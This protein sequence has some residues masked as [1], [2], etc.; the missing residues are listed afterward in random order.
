MKK[1]EIP[2]ETK[3][4]KELKYAQIDIV[5]FVEKYNLPVWFVVVMVSLVAL[6]QLGL[7]YFIKDVWSGIKELFTVKSRMI[8]S[9]NKKIEQLENRV[10]AL[11]DENARLREVVASM[12]T[13][14]AYLKIQGASDLGL[15]QIL[16]NINK[17]N[18]GGD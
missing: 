1:I 4:Y 12:R 10:E 15:E 8:M 14:I 3:H 17:R 7:I 13:L 16:E 2:T 11:E 18:A 5:P 6:K 9:L